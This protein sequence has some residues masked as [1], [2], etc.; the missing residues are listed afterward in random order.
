MC[1]IAGFWRGRESVEMEQVLRS[2]TSCMA[3]RGPD[4]EGSWINR[5][6][7]VALG[8]RRLS[9]ID[10]SPL[11]HQPMESASGRYVVV[12]NGE[13]Y[14]FVRV[15]EE[16]LAHGHRFRGGSD[17]EV[18]LAAIEEWG[19]LEALQRLEGM[20]ALGLWDREEQ[21]LTLARD[22]LGEKPLYYSVGESGVVFGSELKA[23]RRYPG[24]TFDIDRGAL[25]LFFRHHY[26]PAPHTIFQGVRK[27]MPG[28]FVTIG[29]NGSFQTAETCYWSLP[30]VALRGAAQPFSGSLQD[31]AEELDA[32]LKSVVRDE[33][34]SDVPLGAFLSGGIDSSTV[35]G[36]MQRV[37][38]VPVRTF[39]IG[40][41]EPAYDESPHAALVARH[42]GTNHTELMVTPQDARNV[43]PLL[44]SI[45]DEPFADSSQVP[46][47]LVSRMASD[48]VTVS[49]S[50]DGGDELFA[51][52]S[53][54][55]QAQGVWNGLQRKPQLLRSAL[56]AAMSLVPHA[57]LASA[58]RTL[59]G[60][61]SHPA[62]GG[63]EARWG[64]KARLFR[65]RSD[66]EV[67]REL[68]SMWG[69][70]SRAVGDVPE[71][72]QS[73]TSPPAG[74]E[75][76]D[77]IARLCLVDA[78]TYLPDDIM[79]KVDRAAMAVSL[80]TRAPFLHPAVVEFAF[81]LPAPLKYHNG[82]GKL[83]LREVLDR[84]VPREMV[85]RPK[86]GFGVPIN[87][88]LRGEL[89]AWAD[90]CLSE[91][92]LRADG[93]LSPSVVRDVWQRHRSGSED[94]FVELWPVL[95][96]QSWLE[97]WRREPV[98]DEAAPLPTGNA[99]VS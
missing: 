34:I 49:L 76:L 39:T 28:T 66:L 1:G 12:F 71:P 26:I 90:D 98:T 55:P 86:Q 43:I 57:L 75:K 42:L 97:H 92:S 35:V 78:L 15:R 61:N 52:Y 67:F 72:R 60:S 93:F 19:V 17:T 25:A 82:R 51:G 77:P 68:V 48:H 94:R 23:L 69:D 84:Y 85:E 24:A 14:N 65:A 47:F 56:G 62:P 22:R 41:T 89:R 54:Y 79:V 18:L 20:F 88:W 13:L 6:A 4:D 99:A 33:M 29:R 74:I 50:G 73:F 5:D 7:G 32:L 46:T 36:V 87:E 11:G 16:L 83:V 30:E 80:E 3:H 9:I 91:Q 27:V 58:G 8:H 95:M 96:F 59:S 63:L 44:P 40:F 21:A 45:Y 31:A 37:A 38:S 64:R 70:P 10:V 2:M 53:R 81:R